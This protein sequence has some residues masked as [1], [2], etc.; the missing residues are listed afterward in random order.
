MRPNFLSSIVYSFGTRIERLRVVL[1][2]KPWFCSW[3]NVIEL[4]NADLEGSVCLC[5][6]GLPG[7][8]IGA[9]FGLALRWTVLACGPFCPTGS[10]VKFCEPGSSCQIALGVGG[11]GALHQA[12]AYHYGFFIHWGTLISWTGE[13]RVNG[14]CTSAG[15]GLNALFFP[16]SISILSCGSLRSL[17]WSYLSGHHLTEYLCKDHILIKTARRKWY[18]DLVKPAETCILYLQFLIL[19]LVPFIQNLWQ[20]HSGKMPEG[21]AVSHLIL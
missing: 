14:L 10:P 19:S 16:G 8:A 18:W 2:L 6:V 1:V 9:F 12:S 5:F 11:G 7:L 20:P 17:G 15:W 21:V 3:F 13:S 4:I